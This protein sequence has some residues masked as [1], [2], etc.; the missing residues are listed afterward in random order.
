MTS[1]GSGERPTGSARGSDDAA[2]GADA[3]AGGTVGESQEIEERSTGG[4]EE[5]S[6][7]PTP[8]KNP[9][10]SSEQGEPTALSLAEFLPP[11]SWKALGVFSL[12]AIFAV[13]WANF[14]DIASLG[15][16]GDSFGV[17]T[18]LATFFALIATA[19]AV[20]LQ[21]QELRLQ[22]EELR[23]SRLEMENQR[24]VMEA[25]Q[26]QMA[27]H[28]KLLSQQVAGQRRANLLAEQRIEVLNVQLKRDTMANVIGATQAY[29]AMV[30]EA[31]KS[32]A[33]DAFRMPAKEVLTRAIEDAKAVD[34]LPKS[35]KGFK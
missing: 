15:A 4:T 21:R 11:G 24:R 14:L 7:T 19:S 1:E 26:E 22:R 31:H 34:I 17:L 18:S 33:A 5:V 3:A 6:L 8:A 27:L 20:H 25:Q 32:A 10:E 35:F 13:G 28:A 9:M 30:P 29:A 12:F 2:P 16:F 23:A